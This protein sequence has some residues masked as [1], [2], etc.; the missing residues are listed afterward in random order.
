MSTLHLATHQSGLHIA[1]RRTSN[2][3]AGIKL[4]FTGTLE[5]DRST[6]NDTA[7]KYGAKVV[8]KLEDTDYIS[9]SSI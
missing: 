8:S 7:K 5:M 9:M 2:A 4:L 6:C 3:L 1:D